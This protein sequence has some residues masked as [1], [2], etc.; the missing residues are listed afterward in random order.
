MDALP[1]VSVVIPC[2]NAAPW[3]GAQLEAVTSQDYRGTI[4]VIVADNG[5][6]DASREIAGS[7]PG[8]TVIDASAVPGPNHARNAGYRAAGGS[9]ILTC[10]ADDVVDRGWV[11]AMVA[12]LAE[13][14]LV[15]GRLDVETL[16]PPEVRR[17]PLAEAAPKYGFLPIV[18]G[19]NFGIRRSVLEALGGWNE[20]FTG[21]PDDTELCWRAQLAG[22]RYGRTSDAVV[23]YRY[24]PT[25]RA[26]ARQAYEGGRRIP[27][28]VRT[29][30]HAGMS[31]RGIAQRALRFAGYLVVMLPLVPFSR[32]IRIEWVR[33]ASLGWGFLRGL[34]SRSGDGE[35]RPPQ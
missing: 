22:Y 10:D 24:R 26:A 17:Q 4:E 35:R 20:S 34:M 11:S 21:G 29:F 31:Y 15:G 6:T 19:G 32:R 27:K 12:A 13:F 9:L 7:F 25:A 23:F 18:S 8:V 2:R 30:R 16:N 5:S 33:R 1:P 3:L 28:L 14:D